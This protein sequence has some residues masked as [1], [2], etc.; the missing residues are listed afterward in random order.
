[1]FLEVLMAAA[2]APVWLELLSAA[3]CYFAVGLA[4]LGLF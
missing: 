1:M 2:E 3:P 4:G